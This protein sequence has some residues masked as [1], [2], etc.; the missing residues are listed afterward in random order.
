MPLNL[1]VIVVP[2]ALDWSNNNGVDAN[3]GR[4]DADVLLLK[5]FRSH[6]EKRTCF[7]NPVPYRYYCRKRDQMIEFQI[8]GTKAS[9]IVSLCSDGVSKEHH[10]EFGLDHRLVA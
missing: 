1:F 2:E 6:P 5:I 7:I 4:D 3:N 10:T 9:H 8:E